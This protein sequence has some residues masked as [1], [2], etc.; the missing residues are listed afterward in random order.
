MDGN[1]QISP[2]LI[3]WIRL[4]AKIGD[5]PLAGSAEG[6]AN[7]KR[8]RVNAQLE[9]LR[10]QIP[11]FRDLNKTIKA[12]I[13][14]I[15]DCH[16]AIKIALGDTTSAASAS[17]T[18]SQINNIKEL[19]NSMH[20]S[21]GIISITDRIC[22]LFPEEDGFT[23]QNGNK[24]IFSK[25]AQEIT[26]G[27]LLAN[28]EMVAAMVLKN[29]AWYIPKA[30]FP[31]GAVSFSDAPAMAALIAKRTAL[32]IALAMTLEYT[33]STL[34][35]RK[36]KA[37]GGSLNNLQGTAQFADMASSIAILELVSKF[38]TKE[39]ISVA[40]AVS[41]AIPAVG[42]AVQS[43]MLN[44]IGNAIKNSSRKK[45]NNQERFNLDG[46][47][48][49]F[50]D[51]PLQDIGT[52]QGATEDTPAPDIDARPIAS[53]SEAE[54]TIPGHLAIDMSGH[55]LPRG[56]RAR[57]E[58]KDIKP[59]LNFAKDNLEKMQ[60]NVRDVSQKIESIQRLLASCVNDI[61]TIFDEETATADVNSESSEIDIHV[62]ASN[63][64]EISNTDAYDEETLANLK[65]NIQDILSKLELLKSHL[66]IIFTSD[67][68]QDGI[69][70]KAEIEKMI[71][72]IK[73]LQED[74]EKSGGM[75]PKAK[76]FFGA[77]VTGI[78]L[79][80]IASSIPSTGS[81][82]TRALYLGLTSSIAQ[83]FANLGQFLGGADPK[84][85]IFMKVA[86]VGVNKTEDG[87]LLQGMGRALRFLLIEFPLLQAS[88]VFSEKASQVTS[89]IF[90]SAANV[91][92]IQE[93]ARSMLSFMFTK[94]VLD[95]K[96][97]HNQSAGALINLAGAIGLTIAELKKIAP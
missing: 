81:I 62:E 54:P 32:G 3:D 47:R 44:G 14:P 92:I 23:V 19:E 26:P 35:G 42:G 39:H 57:A 27:K 41:F 66:N 45:E 94:I 12:N 88:F 76:I 60:E 51:I 64:A 85:P 79:G 67:N 11:H 34:A 25:I 65:T 58:S 73:S 96:Y 63:G 77:S 75:D 78:V 95:E 43:G 9:A 83:V 52:A 53:D 20:E 28:L 8:D 31:S 24:T 97:E 46:S 70:Q 56:A 68:N 37:V 74:L 16:S 38:I 10:L 72:M 4:V 89:D 33:L 82:A 13:T 21:F 55:E 87:T 6:D 50:Q 7:A 2:D 22:S 84:D 18:L 40:D 48:I 91:R 93:A 71:E 30:I 5:M 15:I 69:E 90:P 61:Q 29:V 36:Q 80:I 1:K 86:K 59:L 49:N 17:L